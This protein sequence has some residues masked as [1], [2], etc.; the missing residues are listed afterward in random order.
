MES[1]GPPESSVEPLLLIFMLL[2][3]PDTTFKIEF[4]WLVLGFF[5]P[6]GV[7]QQKQRLQFLL[8]FFN[9]ED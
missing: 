6:H 2:T 5:S 7:S 8:I 4:F 1:C 9:E 3:S